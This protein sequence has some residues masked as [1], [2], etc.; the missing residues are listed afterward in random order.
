MTDALDCH[1]PLAGQ[2]LSA[3]AAAELAGQLKVIADPTRLRL[4]SMISAHADREACVCEL[5][6]PLDLTQPTVSHH[7]KMLH[8]AGLVTRSRRGTWVYY[9]AV[10]ERLAALAMMIAA[11][12]A[13]SA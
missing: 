3:E 8:D 4:L 13:T 11:P 12:T 2:P 10:P 6:T 9:R 5:T 1:S 7:L